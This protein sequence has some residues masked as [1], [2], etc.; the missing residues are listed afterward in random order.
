MNTRRGGAYTP[1]ADA[2][3]SRNAPPPFLTKTYDLVDDLS[4]NPIV[5][6]GADGQSFIVWKPAEFAR[7]LLP[8]HFKHNNF[9][10]FVRQLN[11]YGFRKVDPDRWEFA[12]E[13]FLRGRRDL[14]ADIHRRK[15][16]GGSS[17]R[18]RG[19]HARDDED[20]QQIIEVG[21]YGLQQ[22]VEQLKRDKN[23][24]MQEVIRLRQ[25]QQDSNDVLVD[26]QDRLDMQEQRQ[27]QMIGFLAAALQNPGLV[28][29]LVASTPIIKRIDDG[30]RRKK[31]KGAGGSDSD[32]DGGADSPDGVHAGTLTLAQPQQG[33]ADLAQKFMAMLT[34]DPRSATKPGRP[35]SRRGG[36]DAGRRHGG[37]PIIE[38][39][40][41]ASNSG[42]GGAAIPTI[43]SM[44]VGGG[45][46][47]AAAGG[48]G[49]ILMGGPGGM[50]DPAA[51][52]AGGMYD[53]A[54][55]GGMGVSP[56]PPGVYDPSTAFMG[57]PPVTDFMPLPGA[58][59]SAPGVG[60]PLQQLPL[61]I[62]SAP[63]GMMPG[64]NGVTGA[65][66]PVASSQPIV[67][68]PD[69]LEGLSLGGVDL[70]LSDMLPMSPNVD[71]LL[72]GGDHGGG[73]GDFW[74]PLGSLPSSQGQ[75][76]QQ[77]QQQP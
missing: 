40:P 22:E 34:T 46:A 26:L 15:P 31:R 74:D 41:A 68:L 51:A 65:A 47:A 52:A 49:P 19:G 11:T 45:A 67:E 33:L 50:Y 18:R 23:V 57:V 12:N 60:S 64:M 38:E 66:P 20:R 27:Q 48:T 29:H 72:S 71:M 9:S 43:T 61:P 77:Q 3:A 13:H 54:A 42:P 44:P 75:P 62:P 59:G 55:G 30:R 76:P 4:S 39:A 24:L 56:L 53:A 1:A 7:D 32:S 17:E 21:H 14:L 6:W 25:Q 69:P 2:A 70:D 37:G 73:S 28:Q 5:S 8:M 35:S 16:T 36:R 63:A 10:S 58:A